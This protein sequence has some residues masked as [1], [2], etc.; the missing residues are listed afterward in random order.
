MTVF[1]MAKSTGKRQKAMRRQS[2][3]DP[4]SATATLS[5]KA[6]RQG[7]RAW[8]NLKANGERMEYGVLPLSHR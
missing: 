7:I 6:W 5:G 8:Q 4:Q 3:I 1:V 2:S